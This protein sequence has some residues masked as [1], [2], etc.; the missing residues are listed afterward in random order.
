MVS[1]QYNIHLIWFTLHYFQ[2]LQRSIQFHL[3]SVNALS[4]ASVV[5][6][7]I[8][9]LFFQSELRE[10]KSYLA[11]TVACVHDLQHLSEPVDIGL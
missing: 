1:L 11:E 7:V 4:A 9:L 3:I 10:C 6:H 8:D 2:F 5:K